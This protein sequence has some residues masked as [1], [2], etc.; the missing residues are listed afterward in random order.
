MQKRKI[1]APK[2]LEDL[3]YLMSDMIAECYND[4]IDLRVA[5]RVFK[6]SIVLVNSVRTQS[7]SDNQRGVSRVSDFLLSHKEIEERKKIGG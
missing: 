2:N 5:D 6:A 1:R 3:N 7:I 4:E